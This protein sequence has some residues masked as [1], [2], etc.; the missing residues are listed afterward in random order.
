MGFGL[1][2]T[3]RIKDVNVFLPLLLLDSLFYENIVTLKFLQLF[4]NCYR[5]ELAKKSLTLKVIYDVLKSMDKDE[6]IIKEV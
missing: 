4:L 2:S 3:Q 5:V 1:V 6:V